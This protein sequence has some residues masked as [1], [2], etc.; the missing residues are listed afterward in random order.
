MMQLYNLLKS[1]RYKDKE[2]GKNENSWAGMGSR[3]S[4][5]RLQLYPLFKK[6]T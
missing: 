1:C 5:R 4:V 3:K 6:K 2:T